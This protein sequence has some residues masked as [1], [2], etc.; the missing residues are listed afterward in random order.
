MR[1]Y[2]CAIQLRD[3]DNEEVSIWGAQEVSDLT[4]SGPIGP[5]RNSGSLTVSDRESRLGI[6]L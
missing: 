6:G 4:P 3:I 1:G 2:H 5:R